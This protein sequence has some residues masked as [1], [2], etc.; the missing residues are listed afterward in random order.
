M[1]V[2][3]KLSS[4]N[5]AETWEE[6]LSGIADATY[7]IT[8]VPGRSTLRLEVYCDSEKTAKALQ[9]EHGG[10]FR[11]LKKQNWTAH[12]SQAPHPVKIRDT[13]VVCSAR[14]SAECSKARKAFPHREVIAVPAD[15]AFGTGHHATTAT[16]LR[17][18]VDEAKTLRAAGKKWTMADLGCGSG[19]LAI[20]ASKLGASRAWGCDFDPAAVRISKENAQ[21][22]DTPEVTF[23][24]VDVLKW[25]PKRRW[26]I[27]AANIFHDVL[28][29]AF[30]QL[31]RSVA[32]GGLLMLSGILR[33]QAPGCLAAG[34]RAGFIVE[35]VV[36]KGKWVTAMGRVRAI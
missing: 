26:D 34:K 12:A 7:V 8:S 35:K 29:A 21:R 3:T 2:W 10:T 20:A 4:A 23:S 18:M 15:M 36:T 27:V 17:L 5:L 9:R 14:T 30:P 1:L 24:K 25:E 32:P 22:N 33:S 13:F 11:R 19:I 16:V 28:E 6:N 31:L